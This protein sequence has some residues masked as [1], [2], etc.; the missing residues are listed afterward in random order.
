MNIKYDLFLYPHS[1][2]HLTGRSAESDYI[3]KNKS[4]ISFGT[5]GLGLHVGENPSLVIFLKYKW[6][7]RVCFSYARAAFADPAC[8][9]HF[10]ST[11][12]TNTET[13]LTIRTVSTVDF[14]DFGNTEEFTISTSCS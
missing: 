10:P 13:V 14:E 12:F 11:V 1:W 4:Q 3:P 7:L 5:I 6:S 8:D 2:G 9:T